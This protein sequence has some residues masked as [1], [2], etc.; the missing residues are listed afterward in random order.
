MRL[1]LPDA[2]HGRG[3]DV[4]AL[5]AGLA[6]MLVAAAGALPTGLALPLLAGFVL[7]GPGALVQAVFR[8]PSPTRWLVVPAFGVAVVVVVTTAMAWLGAWQPRPS[9][10]VLAGVVTLIAAVRLL[11]LVR[12]GVPAG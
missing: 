8:L 11:P 4:A 9:L 1:R 2:L 12:G 5:A 6:G 7:V 3:W 10:A